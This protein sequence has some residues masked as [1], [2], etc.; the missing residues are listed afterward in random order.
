ME[1]TQGRLG[2][3]AELKDPSSKKVKEM[4]GEINKAMGAAIAAR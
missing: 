2:L 1:V 4:A 3:H